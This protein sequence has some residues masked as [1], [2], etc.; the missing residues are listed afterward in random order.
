MDGFQMYGGPSWLE[1]ICPVC[2]DQRWT[3]NNAVWAL[4][5]ALCASIVDASPMGDEKEIHHEVKKE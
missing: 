3:A 2:A 1:E 5:C 4:H